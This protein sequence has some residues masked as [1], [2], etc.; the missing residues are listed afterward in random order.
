MSETLCVATMLHDD[1]EFLEK[2]IDYYSGQVKDKAHLYVVSHGENPKV[3][4]IAEG[5]SVMVIPHFE[6]GSQFEPRRRKMFFGMVAMLNNYFRHVII[7][8]VD[9]FIVL[10]PALKQTLPE[11][12]DQ[13]DFEGRVLSPLGFDVVHHRVHEPDPYTFSKPL[14][15]QRHYGYLEGAY[16]KPCIFRE[17]P[18]NGGNAHFINDEPWDID[19]NLMLFHMKYFDQEFGLKVAQ[20]RLDTVTG[21]EKLAKTHRIGGWHNRA[22]KL[23]TTLDR[24]EQSQ[25]QELTRE[26]AEQFAREIR[27]DF[28]ARGRFPWATSQRGPFKIPEGFLGTV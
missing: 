27:R 9:E 2:W 17:A 15:E 10:D 28:E 11:Y 12:L 3:R 22:E 21:Y 23:L 26:N 7:T 16:T 13:R 20:K 14:T 24:L 4:E 19:C 18:V 6:N 5:C 8:D 25:I 1:Y